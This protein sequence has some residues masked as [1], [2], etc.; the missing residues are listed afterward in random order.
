M[1]TIRGLFQ[2]AQ[3][4][5]AAYANFINPDTGAIYNTNAG[6]Q[7]ALIAEQFS[8]AQAASF[9]QNW[10]VASQFSE[11]GLLSNGFSATLLERLGANQQPTGQYTLAFRGST[12]IF[13]DFLD[14]DLN[15]AVSSVAAKQLVSMVNYVLRL[16]VGGS[17]TT[18]QLSLNANASG[19][20]FTGALVQGVGSGIA[21]ESMAVSGHSLGGYLAQVYQRLFGSV[22]VFT[23]NALG[24]TDPNASFFGQVSTLLGL[25]SGTFGSGNGENLVVRGEPAQLIGTIQGKAQIQIFTETENSQLSPLNLDPISAHRI[26]FVTD[27]LSVYDLLAK[28][29]PALNTTEPATGINKITAILR[30]MSNQPAQSLETTIDALVNFFGFGFSPL[31]ARVKDREAFYQQ[32][33]Q[34]QTI[35]PSLIA[36]TP[37]QIDSLINTDASSLTNLASGSTAL[38]YRY[39][40]KALNPFAII[41][42]NSLYAIHNEKSELNLYDPAQKTGNLTESWLTERA[43]LLEAVLLRNTQDNPDI[44]VIPVVD[45]REFEYRY[46][47]NGQERVLFAQAADHAP[48][49]LPTELI[50]FA[51]DAGRYLNGSDHVLGD[52]LF[53]GDSADIIEGRGGQDTLE[54]GRGMDLYTYNRTRRNGI[55]GST[56]DGDGADTVLDTDGKGVLRV[57]K[58]TT[59]IGFVSGVETSIAID[60]SVKLNE[61]TWQSA[62]GKFNYVKTNADLVVVING[63]GG[64]TVTLKNWNE[65]DFGIRLLEALRT[66]PQT[67]TEILGDKQYLDLPGQQTQRKLPNGNPISFTAPD[68]SGA[69]YERLSDSTPAEWLNVRFAPG[70]G[71][72]LWQTSGGIAYYILPATLSLLYNEA[73]EF[74]NIRRTDEDQPDLAD[75]LYDT[76]GNDNILAGGGNDNI[77]ALR[78]GADVISA[79][80]GRDVVNAGTGNDLVEG[81]ADGTVVLGVSGVVAGGDMIAGGAGD[82]ELY[83]NVKIALADAIRN[84]E[85]DV[86][87]NVIGDFQSGEAGN[88]WIVG[89]KGNDA[90]LGGD[91]DDILVGGAGNDNLFGDR[92]HTAPDAAWLITR[93]VS[94]SAL[95][96]F[97]YQTLFTGINSVADGVGRDVLYGGAGVDWAFGGKGDDF[98]D[99]GSGADVLFGDEGSDVVIGGTENDVLVGD[100]VTVA[101]EEQGADYLDGGVGNDTLQGD[102]GDDI[103]IGD[104]GEDILSGGAGNDILIG[105]KGLDQLIG[106][107]GKDTYVFN[108]GDGTEIIVD[109]AGDAK[110]PEASVLVLGDGISQR[111]IKFRPGSLLVDLGPSNP[112]DPL[113]GN[114]QI[115]FTNFN[116]DFPDL[117]AAIGEIR[118]ADGSSMDYADIL[119]QGFDIDGTALDDAGGTAL[120]GTSVTDRIRGFAGSDE[121]EGRD[122]NDV[123][124]GDGGADRLD[125]GNGNDVLDGGTGNDLLAGGMGSDDYRFVR[126]DGLDSVV[127][128]SLFVPGLSD[129]G[130][131]DRI[132]FGQGITRS[133]VSLLR[134][135]DGNLTVRYGAGD[136]IL[137]EGQYGVPGADIESI[138]FA[139]GE[140]IDKAALDVLEIGVI[141]GT[142]ATDEL[143]GTASNDVLRGHDGDDYLDGGPSP[144]RRTTGTRT[145]TGDD[146]LEGGTGGDNYALYWGMGSDRIIETTDGQSNTLALLNAGTLDGVRT[147]RDGDDLLVTMR[148]NGG[149]ARVQGFFA[150]GGSDAWQITSAV[151]GSQSLL[152]FHNTQSTTENP[153]AVDAMADYKQR[154]L[155]EWQAQSQPNLDLPT[156]VYINSTWSQTIAQWTTLVNALPEPVRQTVTWVNA[157]VTDTSIGG[158]GIRQGAHIV[159]LPLSGN[160]ITQRLVQPIVTQ[161]I[162]DDAYIAARQTPG[163]SANS[164]SYTFNAGGGGP[165]SNPRTYSNQNGFVTNTIT[166]SSAEGWV[167]LNLRSDGLGQFGLR[168]HQIVENPVIEDI[169]AGSSN[170][171]IVGMLD[172]AGD[173]IALIDAGA[174]NDFVSAGQFDFAFGNDGNDR[175]TG[176][177]YAF[178]GNGFDILSDGRFIAGGADDDLLS[179]GEG[180]TTFH[181]RSGEAGWD[182]VRDQ[183]GVSLT[184]FMSRAG[185]ADS[186]SNLVYGGKYRLGGETSLHFQNALEARFGGSSSDAYRNLFS[187][188]TYAELDLGNGETQ[189][190]TVLPSAPGFPRGIA[191]GFFRG[192]Y[193]SDGYYTWV[194]NSI[195]DMM[196]DFADLGLQFSPADVQQIP[197]APDLSEFTADNHAA[198]RPFFESGVLAKDT[199]ELAD[200]ETNVDEITTGFATPGEYGDQNRVLRL[201][202]GTDKVIDIELPSATDLIGHGIEEIIFGSDP[203]YIGD[204]VALAEE[205]GYLGTSFDDYLFGTDT[206]DRI[207]G[208]AGWDYIDG[209]AGNDVLSGGAGIDEFYF[210]ENS[211]SDTI[212]DPDADDLI[213]FGDGI[214]P[215]QIQLGL[216]SLR[217]RYGPAGDEIHFQGFNPDDVHGNT[218]F[219]ALQFWDVAQGEELPDGSFDPIWTL[220]NELTYGEVLERGFDI[221]GTDNDDILRGTNIHDRFHDGGGNDVLAGGAGG[222]SYFFDRGNGAD[223]VSDFFETGTINRIVLRDRVA[224]D[225]SGTRE[226]GQVV[227]RARASADEIRIQWDQ[228]HGSGVDLVEFSDGSTWSR[229]ILEQLPAV[230]VN[231][232]PTVGIPP[233]PQLVL[234]DTAFSFALPEGSFLD[235]DAGDVLTYSAAQADDSPLPEWLNFDPGSGNFSGQPGNEHVGALSVKVT[236]SDSAGASVSGFF[237]ITVVN[238]NDAPQYLPPIDDQQAS[239]DLA[240]SFVVPEQRFSDPDSGDALTY[241]AR[242]A[243]GSPLP[244]WLLFDPAARRFSGTP[245]NGDVGSLALEVTA[246][247]LAGASAAG[248]FAVTVQNTNDAPTTVHAI[249]DQ[250]A[251]ENTAFGFAIPANTFL[252]VDAG[253]VLAYGAGLPDGGP[254]PAWMAFD[255][256]TGIFSGM[257]PTGTAGDFALRVTATDRAGAQAFADFNLT[258]AAG[259]GGIT[260]IGT[261]ASESLVGTAFND[262]IEGRGGNDTLSGLEGDDLLVGGTGA[263]RLLGGKGSD[264]LDGR[265]GNDTLKGGKGADIYLFGRGGGKDIIDD[266]GAAG[267]LD[268]VLFGDGITLRDLRFAKNDGDLTISING[269][270]DRLTIRDWSSRKDSIETLRFANG[271]AIDLREVMRRSHLDHGRDEEGGDTH[272]HRRGGER[273]G[274]RNHDAS[275]KQDHDHAGGD[276]KHDKDFSRLIDKWFDE[277]RHA[278][279]AVQSWLD[280][281]RDGAQAIKAETAAIR[282]GWAASEQWLRDHPRGGAGRSENT[283]YEEFSGLPWLS[284]STFESGSGF[285]RNHLPTLDGHNLKPFR[286]LEEGLRALG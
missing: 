219:A 181:F 139:D 166:E 154:L 171:S 72:T 31:V 99:G 89:D 264:I 30:A 71:Y 67:T 133:D 101:F 172:S 119:A 63:E 78:S 118:F 76:P 83:G 249:A 130:H 198:L 152:D 189:R 286:G 232:S 257:P 16:A 28:I 21:P 242:L 141:D 168:I 202:W 77:D 103:L 231:S 233:R 205:E 260:L 278:G 210:Q 258:V 58:T 218:L 19:L 270:N 132:L 201:L 112:D 241:A 194:Y 161:T 94:G 135:G 274:R 147:T 183:N 255:A 39:A 277:R 49:A 66:A 215:E 223:I 275:G 46:Y 281:S 117:T 234:E 196:R 79:G 87:T 251:S 15:L 227:L 188:L 93:Q 27:A 197:G 121:L 74:G 129:P 12:E 263:D 144:E 134:T 252:D 221:A 51:D 204:L 100:G 237:D 22:G 262:I 113:A 38:A 48:G 17:G 238:V 7:D 2:Q 228:A 42:D 178:G 128:G 34:L 138:V 155:G 235:P 148:G 104:V 23:F 10:R 108:R 170:N 146:V 122:G 6:I 29:D 150:A 24:V 214:T 163:I 256:L 267:D 52:K 73:D 186:L 40:L 254:L 280:E 222:D 182:Q 26:P 248:T 142:A 3:L 268:T 279:D 106:G 59:S 137:I 220:T 95:S 110:I 25:P 124:T 247:D 75:Q 273:D 56:V 236:A 136:E 195:E 43:K 85:T 261:P 47:E 68:G 81:G 226:D 149:S 5:E 162:T 244:D 185:F 96:G 283:G 217:L 253:D 206:D 180:E 282:A 151:E 169:E 107:A 191:D 269:T 33:V 80:A 57:V 98:I 54:G 18:Q 9:V 179:G 97:N 216:G 125:G 145:F 229:A 45:D 177:A 114:D 65:G 32:V 50:Q 243:D 207:R 91:G 62:D 37:L 44:A 64:G 164:V 41:G 84:G 60:A 225:I 165:F 158:Y 88:D 160:T 211:G 92:N 20:G 143:Y 212:L 213:V 1:N 199:V 102:G 123:L 90:L 116:N 13:N 184:E 53:G 176:G 209:G 285:G 140:T 192:P 208:L 266:D 173:R 4:A 174:G 200:F 105:G 250:A 240:F 284:R 153:Y 126:G 159:G 36:N 157:P 109:T 11:T 187:A 55:F 193:S 271:Q 167:S 111:D 156:H 35:I 131:T 70:S 190:Y 86:A 224:E 239:E 82:D 259:S 69:V 175:I 230:T 127:E 203:V 8:P 14:A 120:I 265:R 246:T 272:H 61:T 115:H 276:N 245:L